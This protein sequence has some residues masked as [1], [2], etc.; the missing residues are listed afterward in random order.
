MLLEKHH[1]IFTRIV[2]PDIALTRQAYQQNLISMC[3]GRRW[4]LLRSGISSKRI[5][6]IP[7]NTAACALA[8]LVKVQ[9]QH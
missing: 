8:G 6:E 2:S 1:S 3:R 4:L 5:L 7:Q 9:L